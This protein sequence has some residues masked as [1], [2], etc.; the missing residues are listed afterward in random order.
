MF[1]EYLQNHLGK[2]IIVLVS[3]ALVVTGYW[4]IK[5]QEVKQDPQL[6]NASS[7]AASF[8]SAKLRAPQSRKEIIESKTTKQFVDLKG[9]IKKPGVYEI[10]SE[11][12]LGTL[13]KKA[14]G[15][16]KGADA[17]KINL[18]QKLTDQALIYI[19]TT[20]ES[21]SVAL[22]SSETSSE[23]RGNDKSG[24]KVNLNTATKEEL[25]QLPGVGA[26]KAEK[27]FNYR[28]EHGQFKTIEDLKEVP[29][30][31]EKTFLHFKDQLIV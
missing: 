28:E 26:K 9:A 23:L 16:T 11:M 15:L 30:I 27:I 13:I 4:L 24:V 29:G 18:A 25:Q 6:I 14:G 31:G 1:K 19:P 22:A 20:A 5:Q 8:T 7:Q 21:P 10:T 2:I 3:L 17:K 12:R